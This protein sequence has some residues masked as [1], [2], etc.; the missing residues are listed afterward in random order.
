MSALKSNRK[1]CLEI[2]VKINQFYFK[3]S[4][5]QYNTSIVSLISLEFILITQKVTLIFTTAVFTLCPSS[6]QKRQPAKKLRNPHVHWSLIFEA[7]GEKQ[8]QV[9]KMKKKKTHIHT[10]TV[11]RSTAQSSHLMGTAQKFLTQ[12]LSHTGTMLES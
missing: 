4:K 9:N 10:H 8:I 2:F 5:T 11:V 7:L 6:S 12:G 3:S 1:K